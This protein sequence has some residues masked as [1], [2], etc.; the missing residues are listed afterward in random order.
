MLDWNAI[1]KY[2]KK[3]KG[4]KN[5]KILSL[6][7]GGI[8]GIFPAQYLAKVEEKTGK[9]TKDYFDLVTGTSTGGI[10]ALGIA[11]GIPMKN[12]VDLYTNNASKIFNNFLVQKI[13]SLKLP[14]M[15][16][17]NLY[18]RNEL[19][20]ILKN[21]FKDKKINDSDVMLCIPSIE[22]TTSKPKVYKTPHDKRFYYDKDLEMWKV[23][24]ATSAAPFYF[25]PA[26][27]DGCKIDGGL[28][29]NNPILVGITEAINHKINKDDIKVLSIGN[30]K[31]IYEKGINDIN[32]GGFISWKLNVLELVMNA[33]T[34]SAENI[35]K[36][37]INKENITRI[38]F[39]TT[40]SINMDNIEPNYLKWLKKQADNK[41]ISSYKDNEMVEDK[42]FLL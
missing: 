39:E 12:I 1:Q 16:F 15:M 13:H 38:D 22:Y 31:K 24:L 37:I 17:H 32:L 42:F 29:A 6:D 7:G 20:N 3:Y 4:K 28:W 34:T 36:Y 8:K 23:A 21:E 27:E 41:F 11:A 18:N 30:G 35:A 2:E 26:K 33:Q 25:K 40:K 14:F 19:K 10:I 5:F 9:L